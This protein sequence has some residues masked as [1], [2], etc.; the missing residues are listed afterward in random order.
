MVSNNK[1]VEFGLFIIFVLL[2]PEAMLYLDGRRHFLD[3]ESSKS[4]AKL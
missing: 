3:T 2:F 4:V 1:V